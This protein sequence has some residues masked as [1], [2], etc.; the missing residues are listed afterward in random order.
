MMDRVIEHKS[1]DLFGSPL[2]ETAT[3]K[4]PLK[5][6]PVLQNQACYFYVLKGAMQA[7]GSTDSQYIEQKESLLA[8]CGNSF[9]KILPDEAGVYQGVAIHFHPEVL[10]KV[11]ADGLPDFLSKPLKLRNK[12]GLAKIKRDELFSRYIDGILFYFNNQELVTDE[13]LILK[14]KELMLLLANTKDAPVVYEVLSNLF[15]PQTIQFKEVI[16]ANIF[17]N[18]SLEDLATLTNNS[19]SSFKREFK[20]IF[21]DSPASYIRSKKLE[22]AAHLLKYTEE[23][24]GNIAY[25]CGFSDISHFSKVFKLKYDVAPSEWR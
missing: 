24:I 15:S 22:K 21:Q 11:Y 14:L 17:T 20:K 25:D 8:K 3:M 9:G 5:M 7:V 18:A 6:P 13:I 19:L 12:T 10:K 2:F 1:L 23:Q 4:A 16:E